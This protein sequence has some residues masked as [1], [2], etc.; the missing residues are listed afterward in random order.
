MS[1]S[2]KTPEGGD[3]KE[4]RA[5]RLLRSSARPFVAALL[6]VLLGF[7]CSQLPASI[8]APCEIISHVLPAACGVEESK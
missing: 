3:E 7:V 5:K 8:R 4:T 6:G 1:E 2:D